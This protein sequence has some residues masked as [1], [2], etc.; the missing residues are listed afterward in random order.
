MLGAVLLGAWNPTWWDHACWS[1]VGNR[2]CILQHVLQWNKFR[3]SLQPQNRIIFSS[4]NINLPITSYI[5]VPWLLNSLLNNP[6][7]CILDHFVRTEIRLASTWHPYHLWTLQQYA[8]VYLSCCIGTRIKNGISSL[9]LSTFWK[10][11]PALD[12]NATVLSHLVRARYQPGLVSVDA[13]LVR[14]HLKNSIVK[15][16]CGCESIVIL[17][18]LITASLME[19]IH[20]IP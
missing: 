1:I 12:I 4:Y 20:N 14:I 16:T 2:G 18:G 3:C 7:W 10:F 9:Q 19:A 6:Y 5:K 17:S 8:Y 15:W 13:L 11:S